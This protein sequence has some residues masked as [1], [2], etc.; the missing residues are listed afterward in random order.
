MWSAPFRGHRATDVHEPD[1]TL[2]PMELQ[3]AFLRWEDADAKQPWQHS[4]WGEGSLKEARGKGKG[5]AVKTNCLSLNNQGNVG[6]RGDTAKE[7]EPEGG[8]TSHSPRLQRELH[9]GRPKGCGRKR[10]QSTG[11]PGS[12]LPDHRLTLGPPS[13]T[14]HTRT[15]PCC[16]Q[17]GWTVTDSTNDLSGSHIPDQS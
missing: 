5:E 14:P 7:E 15:A 11:E 3:T 17:T 9:Y 13:S 10:S 4:A 8:S 6:P 2:P 1:I 12:R 16:C